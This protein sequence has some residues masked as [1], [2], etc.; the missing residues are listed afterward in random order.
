MNK[1]DK[2][3]N[4][5][6]L[7]KSFNKA[8]QRRWKMEHQPPFKFQTA[9]RIRGVVEDYGFPEGVVPDDLENI[10]PRLE[11]VIFNRGDIEEI[12][13]ALYGVASGFNVED[14][15]YFLELCRKGVY[16]AVWS[17]SQPDIKPVAEHIE[18]R[19]RQHMEWVVSPPTLKK[20]KSKL[21]RKDARSKRNP[22][23]PL[24]PR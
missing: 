10:N 24:G 2:H 23:P 19:V 5:S 16:P 13:H 15:N 8:A 18:G 7:R 20:I 21:D 17:R 9:A 11:N 3:H 14:I 1:L 6:K 12:Y 4:P 22:V